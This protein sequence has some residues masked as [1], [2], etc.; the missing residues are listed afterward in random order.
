[1]GL[2]A[3]VA[4]AQQQR[5]GGGGGG[6]GLADYCLVMTCEA[7]ED[8]F[9]TEYAQDLLEACG[10]RNT[11]NDYYKVPA[12]S[13]PAWRQKVRQ[14]LAAGLAGLGS[15]RAGQLA[16]QLRQ[17]RAEQEERRRREAAAREAAEAEAARA[18]A[19]F[20]GATGR[21]KKAEEG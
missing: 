9:M 2:W 13:S 5:E 8:F 15:E 3:Q 1:E 10:I 16:A 20:A 6:G 7:D 19:L 11:A 21:K 12:A 14:A 4:A 18:A 17:Q